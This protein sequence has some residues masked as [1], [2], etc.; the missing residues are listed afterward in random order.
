[1]KHD[2]ILKKEYSDKFDELKEI[3]ESTTRHGKLVKID[4]IIIV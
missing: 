2:E 3:A 4:P 1:M